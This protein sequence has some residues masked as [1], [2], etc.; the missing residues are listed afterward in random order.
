VP[1][2]TTVRTRTAYYGRGRTEALPANRGG[3]FFSANHD[4]APA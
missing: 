1:G 2:E 3:A 4:A